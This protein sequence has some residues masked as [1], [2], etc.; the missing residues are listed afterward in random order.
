MMSAAPGHRCGVRSSVDGPHWT[1]GR[2]I[3]VRKREIDPATL[4]RYATASLTQPKDFAR[5]WAPAYDTHGCVASWAERGDDLLA[6]S[7]YLMMVQA[8]E[9]GVA[10]DE[11][12][13]TRQDETGEPDVLDAA[14]RH[15]A[16]GSL[17][18][19]YVRVYT[20]E[21]RTTYTGAFLQAAQCIR[22]M[23]DYPILDESDYSERECAAW[24]AELDDAIGYATRNG[25]R[26]EETDR[27]AIR[28]ALLARLAS[29]GD[30]EGV[31]FGESVDHD[32]ILAL[33]AEAVDTFYRERLEAYWRGKGDPTPW[34]Q[35]PIDA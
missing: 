26:H 34:E 18:T 17:R 7:N 6:E 11:S 4:A 14:D 35:P 9:G 31:T 13:E 23:E 28:A 15:W 10:W 30:R 19:L 22:A 24:Y 20:D 8:C 29:D 27:E 16:V 32:V 2:V 12:A 21:T 25:E 33:W 5:L 3:N 1:I